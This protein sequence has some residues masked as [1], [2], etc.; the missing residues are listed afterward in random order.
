MQI[1]NKLS[2]EYEYLGE[3]EVK[4][5]AD[6]VRIYKVQLEAQSA[7]PSVIHEQPTELRSVD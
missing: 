4:N 3:R 5:I 2:L 6:P 7:A 1:K